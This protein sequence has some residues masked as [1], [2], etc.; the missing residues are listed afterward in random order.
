MEKR[1]KE[2]RLREVRA[3]ED[4]QE[5]KMIIEGYAIVFDEPTD[6]GYIEVIER[7]ALDNCDMSDV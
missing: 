5:E 7:G 3:I 2:V 4:E 6:L 1:I